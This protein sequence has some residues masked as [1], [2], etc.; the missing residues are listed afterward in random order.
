[1]IYGINHLTHTRAKWYILPME[2]SKKAKH[3]NLKKAGLFN[4]DEDKVKD[5]LFLD[6]PEFFDPCDNLQ[7]RYEVLRSHRIERDT[8]TRIC[9]RFGISRQT[10]YTLGKKFEEG[11]TAG[12]IPK[13]P[14]PRGPRKLTVEVLAFVEKSL[15]EEEDISAERLKTLIEER[16][17]VSLHKRTIEKVCKE[18]WVKKN[19]GN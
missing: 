4:P 19:S 11:G 14:G 18:F 5:P 17:G 16:F 15:E 6:H 1:M 9:K 2:N 7:V 13:K 12:L 3:E 8:I 10:F